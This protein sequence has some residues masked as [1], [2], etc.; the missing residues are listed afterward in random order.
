MAGPRLLKAYRSDGTTRAIWQDQ[1]GDSLRK[2]GAIPRRASRVEVIPDGPNRGNFHVDLTLL[3]EIT[4]NPKFAVCLT[5][6]FESYSE[7]VA[8]E[9]KFI[10]HNWVLEGVNGEE[11]EGGRQEDDQGSRGA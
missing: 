7:A 5:K 9:V 8:A 1:I 4:G 2:A 3:S 11:Q 6:T 10:E